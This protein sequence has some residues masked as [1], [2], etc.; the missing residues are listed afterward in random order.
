MIGRTIPMSHDD[1]RD[2]VEWNAVMVEGLRR[3]HD[4][5]ERVRVAARLHEKAGPP[6]RQTMLLHHLDDLPNQ[7]TFEEEP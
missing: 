3:Y 4:R 2:T 6:Q 1:I 5:A 7:L